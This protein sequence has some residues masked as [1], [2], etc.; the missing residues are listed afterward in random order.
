MVTGSHKIIFK[1]H[2]LND[3]KDHPPLHQ[4]GQICYYTCSSFSTF[5]LLIPS[6]I[7]ITTSLYYV[8]ITSCWHKPQSIF[9]AYKK[10]SKGE[11]LYN[12]WSLFKRNQFT[13]RLSLPGKFSLIF[14]VGYRKLFYA[15]WQASWF[16]VMQNQSEKCQSLKSAALS[17]LPVHLCYLLVILFFKQPL[18]FFFFPSF[19]IIN[20]RL[21]AYMYL[22]SKN[23]NSGEIRFN[24]VSSLS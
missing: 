20:S 17:L 22:Q 2:Q 10:E 8:F 9:A 18:L 3:I 19:G 7:Y 6:R 5:K 21:E 11:Y 12:N 14:P 15:Q 4:L 24:L 23:V 16:S 1:Y 13:L